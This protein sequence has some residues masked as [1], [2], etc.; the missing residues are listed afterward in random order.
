MGPLIIG[1][2]LAGLTLGRELHHL[3]PVI[4]EKSRGV[5]GRLATRRLNTGTGGTEARLDHGARE[6]QSAS[7]ALAGFWREHEENGSLWRT[8]KT[9]EGAPTYSGSPSMT[10]LPKTMSLGLEIQLGKR[11]KSLRLAPSSRSWIAECVEPGPALTCGHVLL[12]CPA[13]QIL[14]ILERMSLENQ[15]L[16]IP[17]ARERLKRIEYVPSIVLLSAHPPRVMRLETEPSRELMDQSDEE[18]LAKV[19][20]TFSDA[21]WAQVHRWRYS[22]TRVTEADPFLQ[23]DVAGTLWAAG[24][25]FGDP[26]LPGAERAILSALALAHHWN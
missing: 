11:L 13:P 5:G 24:D 9:W 6:L 16:L 1:A 15:E 17:A 14:E 3:S 4:L 23:L 26:S 20:G 19:R 2:G 18:I 10:S 21:A 12:T 7:P 8:G 22:Q 25:G